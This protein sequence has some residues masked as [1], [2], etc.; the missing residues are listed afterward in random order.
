VVG[1]Q[2]SKRRRFRRACLGAVCGLALL[3]STA[4]SAGASP[5]QVDYSFGYFGTLDI[6]G[7]LPGLNT[8]RQALAMTIGP[9][10]ET[11]VLSARTEPCTG[12]AVCGD[13]F[14]NRF[15]DDGTLDAEFGTRAGAVM[16]VRQQPDLERGTSL[17][18]AV[19]IDS[20][21]RVVVAA[22]ADKTVE[23]ARLNRDG[24]LDTTFQSPGYGQVGRLTTFLTA[25]TTVSSIGLR[26]NGG[27]V[28]AGSVTTSTG[29]DLFLVRY[30][31]QGQLDFLEFGVS[32]IVFGD[33]GGDDLPADI[34]F[35]G[36]NVIVG[37]PVCCV[38][39]PSAA[40]VAEFGPRGELASVF[41]VKLPKRLGAGPAQGVSAVIAGS[42]G[43]TIVVGS[44]KKGTFVA[45]FLPSGRPDPKYGNHGFSLVPRFF[46]EGPAA[47]ALDRRGRVVLSGWRYD[48]PDDEGHRARIV[49][50]F[51]LLPSGRPD[52]TFGGVRPLLTV[53]EGA[54][55]RGL[56]LNRSIAMAPRS[57]AKIMILGE[58]KND[59]RA[60]LITG[61]WFGL[62]RVLGGGKLK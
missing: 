33:F 13:L 29:S 30:L 50:V 56:D 21:G 2:A 4:A 23:V 59:P 3:L 5:G 28:V 7:A 1:A 45:S 32:G 18:G 34:A 53:N 8:Q 39:S 37:S 17:R 6:T 58:A 10:D 14:V 40:S 22:R 27:F 46:V 52:R 12:T 15:G 31:E 38:G 55:K 36:G 35:R 11:V 24:S 49:R 43:A 16:H 26:K 57:D 44:A 47:A 51:R 20:A 61:P 41:E 60:H 25:Q 19:A 48:V 54:Q 42:G 9:E 62:V